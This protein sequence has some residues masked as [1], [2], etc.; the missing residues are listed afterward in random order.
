[1]RLGAIG[2]THTHT[3]VSLEKVNTIPSV[4]HLLHLAVAQS[5][6]TCDS[7]HHP[8]GN[9]SCCSW[10]LKPRYTH[11]NQPPRCIVV[12]WQK[13]DQPPTIRKTWVFPKIMVPP[14]SQIIHSSRVFHYKPSILGYLYFWKHPHLDIFP[15]PI[16]LLPVPWSQSHGEWGYSTLK[17]SPGDTA[18]TPKNSCVNYQPK[19]FRPLPKNAPNSFSFILKWNICG[20]P[21]MSNSDWILVHKKPFGRSEVMLQWK[22]MCRWDDFETAL[23]SQFFHYVNIHEYTSRYIHITPPATRPEFFMF[24]IEKT[25]ISKHIVPQYRLH[26]FLPSLQ[27]SVS[28]RSLIF[29]S[30]FFR[31]KIQ[32][33]N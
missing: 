13:K 1:M 26:P 2:H 14:K 6:T 3:H 30:P 10:M 4:V 20:W 22:L 28:L 24:Q 21:T 7:F 19:F 16:S 12:S 29:F 32:N 15:F 27:T 33:R 11:T 9:G 8:L 31:T 18:G 23:I 17:I 5:S 25:N